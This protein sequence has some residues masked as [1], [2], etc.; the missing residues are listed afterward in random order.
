[1]LEAKVNELEERVRLLA[2][3]VNLMLM[4]GEELP[5]E[6]AEELRSRLNDWIK[7]RRE[8]FIK[9]DEVV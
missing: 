6:E 9:L 2:K 3:A 4:E 5:E 1:M 7:G 8:E